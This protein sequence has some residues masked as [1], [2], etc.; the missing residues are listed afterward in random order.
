MITQQELQSRLDS[1]AR[2]LNVPGASIAVAK[3]DEVVTA[4]T[5]V[6]NVTTGAAVVP[7]TLFA[8]GS[9]TKVFTATLLMTLVDE[10]LV[11]LDTPVCEYLP[12]F[13]VGQD[14]RSAEVTTRMLLNH[15]SG[16]PGNFTYDLPKG[17]DNVAGFVELL[18]KYEFNSPP[19]TYWSYSNAGLVTAGRV[20]EV[21]TGLTF[22]RA[23]A[24]RVL[25]PLGLNATSDTDEMILRSTAVGH[26]IDAQGN[27]QRVPRFQLGT[28]APSGSALACDIGGLVAFGRMHLANGRAGD[29]RQVLTPESVAAMQVPQMELPWRIGYDAFGLGW[30]IRRLNGHTLLGHTGAGAGQH[31]TLDII[32]DQRGVLAALTNSTTGAV[33]FAELC[34]ELL[35]ECFDVRP[36]APVETSGAAVEVDLTPYV[37]VYTADD[38]RLVV[39]QDDGALRV[40]IEA[41]PGFGEMMRLILGDAAFPP[42]P[43]RLTP[44]AADGRFVSDA[45]IPI[46]FVTPAGSD[47]VDYAY[48][49]RIYRRGI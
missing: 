7:E 2:R 12:G 33:L 26:V 41:D 3:G 31:S 43:L 48:A 16:L 29:G 28:N 17:P 47:A 9:V 36:E 11:D 24:D 4:V 30:A 45:G 8:A 23:L 38:G 44:Y 34:A 22:D 35:D 49:G 10:G 1:A 6:T 32:P 15:S 40:R 42:P 13:V 46:Q 20:A 25:R 21:V 19:G 18:R 5:G 14:P 37:G 27:A 39:T